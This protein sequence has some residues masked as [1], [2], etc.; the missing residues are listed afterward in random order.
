MGKER[1][2]QLFII[3]VSNIQAKKNSCTRKESSQKYVFIT[4]RN[5]EMILKIFEMIHYKRLT[6]PWGWDGLY[7]LGNFLVFCHASI[8]PQSCEEFHIHTCWIWQACE[9]FYIHPCWIWYLYSFVYTA[10]LRSYHTTS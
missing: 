5:L 8:V 7:V 9:G 3:L 1:K 4:P 6:C 2:N 10:I